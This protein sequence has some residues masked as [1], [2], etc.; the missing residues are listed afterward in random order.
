[1]P[2]NRPS[3]EEIY[4]ATKAVV[5]KPSLDVLFKETRGGL[6][7]TAI[8]AE[9][10][11]L[12]QPT[13]LQRFAPP[14][15]GLQT[16]GRAFQRGE[17][18]LAEP[19]M[20]AIRKK[21]PVFGEE[22]PAGNAFIRGISGRSFSPRTQW[23]Q[24]EFGDVIEEA[25]RRA[26]GVDIPDPL[27][28]AGGLAIATLA[29]G[30]LPAIAKAGAIPIRASQ[31]AARQGAIRIA[32]G[33]LKPTGKFA[34]R[35][36]QIAEAS[37]REGA[38]RSSAKGTA[39]AA[40]TRIDKLLGEVDA[41]AESSDVVADLKPAFRRVSATAKYWVGQGEPKR[42]L[43][44]LS[45]VKDITT[46][47]GVT[48]TTEMS[49]SDVLKLRRAQDA[50]LKRLKPGGGFWSE[51]LPPGIEARQE[52]AGGLRKILGQAVPE[53]GAK[54]KRISN[55]IDVAKV[56]A[57]REG[58]TSRN[59]LLDI[60]DY[61][62]VTAATKSHGAMPI[63]AAKKLW[64]GSKALGARGLYK[65]SQLGKRIL[66]TKA[67]LPP[68]PKIPRQITGR[69]QPLMLEGEVAP[70]QLGVAREFGEGF[71]RSPLPS[72]I[73]E[74]REAAAQ[75]RLEDL[76]RMKKQEVKPIESIGQAVATQRKSLLRKFG[77]N[78]FTGKMKWGKAKNAYE[79]AL[80]R[81]K[82]KR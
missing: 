79:A 82:S 50:A 46:A 62:L 63:L 34:K 69:L 53:I 17:A 26:L 5:K 81:L 38:L 66:P 35:G 52:F 75:K 78:P 68:S 72:N 10:R 1:M 15:L 12:T 3:L 30:G 67:S 76:L 2:T 19:V 6:L 14:L 28:A 59:N 16:I 65:Y 24:T 55:L 54:N 18:A 36:S 37:L 73:E 8:Q 70:K 57:K 21:Y 29:S 49:V 33:I 20:A 41:L 7:P 11:I 4:S 32:Q 60:I 64:Q 47:R 45:K 74:L 13:A 31:G 25:G 61:F 9:R 80:E 42:A 71:T 23:G 56:A 77:I 48:P 22:P 27:S 43:D 39:E 51:T 44:I 58:V 40:Q